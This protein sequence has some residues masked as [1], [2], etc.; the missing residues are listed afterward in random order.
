MGC[1]AFIPFSGDDLRMAPIWS[2]LGNLSFPEDSIHTYRITAFNIFEGLLNIDPNWFFLPRARRSLRGHPFN[3][4]HGASHRWRRW[5]AFSV[6]ILKYW[7]YLPDSVVRAPSV[8][9]FLRNG[10]RKIGQKFFPISQSC[11]NTHPL[12][13]PYPPPPF[14]PV[15]HSLTVIISL[16]YPTPCFI[17]I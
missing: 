6:R 3:V 17:Y 12:P 8:N 7:N 15:H 13:F 4:L 2:F 14:P 11:L 16:C 5:S 10:W 9:V 1:Y